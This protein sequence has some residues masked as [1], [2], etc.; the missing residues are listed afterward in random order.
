MISSEKLIEKGVAM[1]EK[2]L[3]VLACPLCK[4]DLIYDKQAKELLCRK[5][6][7]AYPIREQI[8]VMLPSEARKVED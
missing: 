5:D 3:D 2:L 7:L 6:K 1:D 4:G 8:P